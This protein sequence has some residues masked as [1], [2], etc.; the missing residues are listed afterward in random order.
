M[1]LYNQHFSRWCGKYDF[2]GHSKQKCFLSFFWADFYLFLMLWSWLRWDANRSRVC[3]VMVLVLKK[4]G[5]C[6]TKMIWA[7]AVETLSLERRSLEKSLFQAMFALHG[8]VWINHIGKA[9]PGNRLRVLTREM[10]NDR[11]GPGWEL[12]HCILLQLCGAAF[13]SSLCSGKGWCSTSV[14]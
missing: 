5:S 3:V 4:T 11:R 10:V 12:K 2:P 6:M 7:K 8:F 1:S 9:F 14:T 13:L